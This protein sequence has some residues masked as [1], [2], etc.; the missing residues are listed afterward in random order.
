MRHDAGV[1]EGYG[2]NHFVICKCIESTRCTQTYTVLHTN[3][4]SVNLGKIITV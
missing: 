3:G 1:G 4:I 2:G